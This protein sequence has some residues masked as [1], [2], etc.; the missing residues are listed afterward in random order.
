MTCGSR[1]EVLNTDT[2]R[3]ARQ[4]L[5]PDHQEFVDGLKLATIAVVSAVFMATVVIGLGRAVLPEQQAVAADR[6]GVLLVALR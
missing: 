5:R 2:I 6:D 4:R 3:L 1:V